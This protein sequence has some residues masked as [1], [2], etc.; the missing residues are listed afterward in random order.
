MSAPPWTALPGAGAFVEAADLEHADPYLVWAQATACTDF[1][2]ETQDPPARVRVLVE[3][4]KG[5]SA[6]QLH[7]DLGREGR[8]TPVYRR[9]PGLRH[10]TAEFSAAACR[11]YAKPGNG[12]V[13]RFELAQ[14]VV[15]RRSALRPPARAT[16]RRT[17]ASARSEGETLLAVIDHGCPF[18]HAAFRRGGK[19]RVLSL[20]DQDREPAFGTP[21]LP[22][23]TPAGFGYGRE[24]C[25][26]EMQTLLNTCSAGGAVDE[27]LT[28]ELA[29]Y[30]ELRRV[31]T[32]GAHVMDQFIGPRRIGDR[33]P[34]L[35]EGSPT[36][37][38]AGQLASDTADLVFV[39]LP[40]D[41][42]AD[43][44]ALA[45][46]ACV[47][48]ALH[49][50]LDCRGPA[51][52]RVVVNLSCAIHTGPHDGSTLIDAA[53]Q[54]LV[55]R[56]GESG[57]ELHIVVP[58][59]NTRQDR[60][61]AAGTIGSATPGQLRLRVPPGHEAPTFLQVWVDAKP[62]RVHWRVQAPGQAKKRLEHPAMVLRNAGQL[63]ALALRNQGPV[64]GPERTLLFLALPAAPSADHA[65]AAGDWGLEVSV[66]AAAGPVRV[67]VRVGRNQSELGALLRH[68][69]AR[70]LDAA[71]DPERYLRR[72]LEDPEPLAPDLQGLFVRRHGTVSAL[73]AGAAVQCVG[74]LMLRPEPAAAD[75]SAIGLPAGRAMAGLS[76][77]SRA[78]PGIRGAGARSACVMRLQGTSF[79][80]PQWA[81]ALADQPLPPAARQRQAPQPRLD[82]LW[83]V[84]PAQPIRL[85]RV[86]AIPRLGPRPEPAAAPVNDPPAEPAVGTK[87]PALRA[88]KAGRVR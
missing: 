81:R 43:P 5:C 56:V 71:Y 29:R 66:D 51:V 48:D 44:N 26:A 47:L 11:R 36:W 57:C 60:W 65:G 31:A 45:L 3:L 7:K 23:A 9:L 10:C 35:E 64:C 18:A 75:Y 40:R 41:A 28:Y 78:L 83:E 63:Q 72:R 22:G 34:L 55:K 19:T 24:V 33:T 14:P 16:A 52:R 86:L 20:W 15:P 46:P 77:E 74:G 8:V 82:D 30:P 80:A 85:G 79:A 32:H 37:Q 21:Q 6:A 67:D 38:A 1:K 12:L 4:I 61:H 59:G 70:L 49:H 73:A 13:A 17:V 58:A 87:P 27:D 54:A 2:R 25:R 88:A 76:D 50:I 42:W 39:Q 62:D 69:A 53:L 68:R 84:T